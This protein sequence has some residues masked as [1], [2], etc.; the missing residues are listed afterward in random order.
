VSDL[1]CRLRGVIGGRERII[2]LAEGRH[3]AGSARAVDIHVPVLGVARRHAVLEVDREALRIEDL[4]SASGTFVDG[5]RVRAAVVPMGAELRLGPVRL[6]VEPVE[7]VAPVALAL[8]QQHQIV[9]VRQPVPAAVEPLLEL[10]AFDLDRDPGALA[11]A[12]AGQ[13]ALWRLCLEGFQA[14][15][16]AGRGDPAP[17]LR[18]LGATLV[19]DGC[20]VVQWSEPGQP[21]S[22]HSLGAWGAQ[23]EPPAPADLARLAGGPTGL[24]SGYHVG[25]VETE[26]PL[27]I[28]ISTRAGQATMALLV[29][30]DYWGRLGSARLLQILLRMLEGARGSP[31]DMAARAPRHPGVADAIL[32]ADRSGRPPSSPPPGTP[33][34]LRRRVAALGRIAPHR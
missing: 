5:V 21:Q 3:V 32:G 18:Y 1:I 23:H 10:L 22:L 14:R 33:R 7:P 17:A 29:W 30:G 2:E 13:S 19:A 34:Y 20:C 27:S 26:P 6:R 15:L 25:F 4:G 28:A 9:V 31:H 16:R 11:A 24:S 8:A 12:S